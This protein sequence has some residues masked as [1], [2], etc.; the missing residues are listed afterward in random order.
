MLNAFPRRVLGASES[1]PRGDE[2]TLMRISKGKRAG[3]FIAAWL[4]ASAGY[5]GPVFSEK[6]NAGYY[7]GPLSTAVETA[8]EIKV[9]KP[10]VHEKILKTKRVKP[11]KKQ[12]PR[13]SNE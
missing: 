6:G 5:S 4:I 2:R 7:A 1:V 8:A 10:V 9:P 12:E 13:D 3:M 11:E